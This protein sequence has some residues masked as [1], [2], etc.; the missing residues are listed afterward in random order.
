MIRTTNARYSKHSIVDLPGLEKKLT[1][2]NP[3]FV[4]QQRFGSIFADNT[5]PETLCALSINGEDV[6]VP[7]NTQLIFPE[8][9]RDD[10]IVDRTNSDCFISGS[11]NFTKQLREYQ[12]RFIDEVLLANKQSPVKTGYLDELYE[13]PCGHGKTVI[14]SYKVCEYGLKTLVLV[15]T[16]DIGEQWL[17][18]FSDFTDIEGVFLP[19]VQTFHKIVKDMQK[20]NVIIMT[21]D[22]FDA[23]KDGILTGNPLFFQSFGLVILDEA[24]RVGAPTYS[25]VLSL[26]PSYRRLALTATFRRSDGLHEFL[27]YDF[28]KRFKMDNQFASATIYPVTTGYGAHILYTVDQ[29]RGGKKNQEKF[30]SSFFD[31]VIENEIFFQFFGDNIFSFDLEYA[32]KVFKTQSYSLGVEKRTLF[33]AILKDIK[34]YN[35]DHVLATADTYFADLIG[36]NRLLLHLMRS[37]IDSGRKVLFLSKRRSSIERFYQTFKRLG[38]EVG[39][40]VGG[41]GSDSME[42]LQSKDC[43]GVFGIYQKAKEGLDIDTLDTLILHHPLKDIE[44]PCGR[45]ERYMVDKLPAIV[46]FPIDEF[47]PYKSIFFSSKK[48]MEKV[49]FFMPQTSLVSHLPFKQ[50]QTHVKSEITNKVLEPHIIS[51][52]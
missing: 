4:S 44:Q 45:I 27:E 6:I 3:A 22:L 41:K 21:F 39:L 17:K 8:H 14:G 24:H 48:M 25:P 46:Y 12:Y 36:R 20:V 19:T 28:G 16:Y 23:R 43:R 18:T 7:R 15:P 1:I 5:V 42:Y 9:F 51:L 30:R 37:L 2:R 35:R 10:D 52:I 32:N 34:E 38:Y 40:K 29:F 47:S 33:S 31:W 49:K 11:K 26:V 13:V 50:P